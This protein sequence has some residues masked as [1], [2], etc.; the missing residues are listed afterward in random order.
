[1]SVLDDKITA[2]TKAVQDETTVEQSAIAL[3]NG[4]PKMIA[5][6][7]AAAQAQ[8]ATPAQLAAFDALAASIET[9]SQSLAK[10]VTDNTPA[11][12]PPNTGG[13]APA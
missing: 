1:L 5:D 4:I 9:N 12:P 13:G 11:A 8:G 2:L 7:I 10:A 3:I 6:A